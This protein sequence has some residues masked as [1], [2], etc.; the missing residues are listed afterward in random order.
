MKKTIILTMF[1]L[2]NLLI[3]C[4]TQSSNQISLKQSLV[5]KLINTSDDLNF[6]NTNEKIIILKTKF[7]KD[8]DCEIYFQDY[9]EQIQIYTREEAFMRGISTYLEIEKI[10]EENG[11][12]ILGKRTKG[13]YEK[14]EIN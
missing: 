7:C 12:I 2:S 14:I 13:K 1:I 6:S 10:D 4:N 9:K 8:F 11:Q 3:A 5:N